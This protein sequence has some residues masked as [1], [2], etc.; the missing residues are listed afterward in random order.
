MNIQ[1]DDVVKMCC[2]SDNV[3]CIDT[4]FNLCSIWVTDCCYDKDRLR[5]NE[6]KTPKF[7]DLAVVH[8]EKDMFLL[9][10]FPAEMLTHE[11]AISNLK[12]IGTYLQSWKQ[13]C[14]T[15]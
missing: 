2:D 11:P 8:F 15:F 13:N 10:R 1:L 5:T 6:D 3:L 12:T 14:G 9:S 7:L 4:A